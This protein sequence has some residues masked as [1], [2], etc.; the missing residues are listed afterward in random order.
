MLLT[1]A[2]LTGVLVSGCG[3]VAPVPTRQDPLRG[4]AGVVVTGHGWTGHTILGPVP[5][6][7]T[8]HYRH[9]GPEV[10]PDPVCTPGAVDSAVSQANL[11]TTVCRK[12]GYT[13][14]VRPPESA[15]N[16]IKRRLLA[17]Y[18]VPV[19]DASKYELDH[20]IELSSGGSS[21]V[22]NL[23]PE[24]NQ[25][26]TTTGSSF[27]HNDKD[28]V[29]QYLYHAQCGGKIGLRAIQ[30]TISR[31]WTT[32]VASLRLPPIPAG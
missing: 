24:P 26:Y 17:A 23:W 32:A 1:G 31:D 10:L 30:Q 29:E 11:R 22:R 28:K 18:G 15:T 2:L 7:G 14:S 13:A 12:G 5:P 16:A 9:S 19:A 4:S 20:L 27:V 3:R 6:P 25:L 21:D 8:C